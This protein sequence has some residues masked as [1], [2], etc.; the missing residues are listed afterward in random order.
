MSIPIE[1]IQSPKGFSFSVC[2]YTVLFLDC[3]E[4]EGKIHL[5]KVNDQS[6]QPVTQ[7]TTI[8]IL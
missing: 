8:P 5:K 3:K 6:L 4:K 2:K 7:H 1:P